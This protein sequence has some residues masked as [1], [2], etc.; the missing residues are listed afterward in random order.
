MSRSKLTNDH[1]WLKTNKKIAPSVK[2][3][4]EENKKVV[5]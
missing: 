1:P 2:N 5:I 3:E 4:I